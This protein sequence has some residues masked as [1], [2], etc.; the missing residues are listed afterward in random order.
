M[1]LS[2]SGQDA[3]ESE[4]TDEEVVAAAESLGEEL[5][6]AKESSSEFAFTTM[7]M[8][9]NEAIGDE[10]GVDYGSVCGAD[11]DGCC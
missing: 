11:D 8:Q 7:V 9:C 1:L 10:T 3:S 4:V 5:A 2:A 6:A